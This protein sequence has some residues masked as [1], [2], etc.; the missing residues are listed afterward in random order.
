[1]PNPPSSRRYN[2]LRRHRSIVCATL[3]V[4]SSPMRRRY[5]GRRGRGRGPRGESENVPSASTRLLGGSRRR[6]GWSG[7][8]HC[9]MKGSRRR[10]CLTH[11]RWRPKKRTSGRRCG[12]RS[13]ARMR[14]PAQSRRSCRKI[15]RHPCIE[16]LKPLLEDRCRVGNAADAVLRKPGE[17][18]G[19][20]GE[21]EESEAGVNKRGETM[22][23]L[24]CTRCRPAPQQRTD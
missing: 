24:S 18:C 8:R 17:G 1:M 22:E 2:R 15:A 13:L 20:R 19:S 6:T 9:I 7:R 12:R 14:L 21:A 11:L 4:S 3:L 23:V 5:R 10:Q 16:R